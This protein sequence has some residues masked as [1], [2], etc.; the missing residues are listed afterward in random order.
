MMPDSS[1]D[2]PS[3]ATVAQV[4]PQ[5]LPPSGS[6]GVATPDSNSRVVR[7]VLITVAIFVGLGIIGVGAISFA[8]WYF[9]K[10]F[11]NVPSATFTESDL[12][13]AIYPGAEPSLRGSRAEIGGTSILSAEYFTRSSVD[14]VISFYREKA[15]PNAHLTTTSHGSELRLSTASGDLTTVK[16]M[17]VPDASGGET[18]IAITRRTKLTVSR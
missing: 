4:Y 18:Y 12:G 3:Q 17:R 15:G 5:P 2:Q 16:I 6:F 8:T 11:H 10:S 7:A 14:Q 13:I 9:A 1:S